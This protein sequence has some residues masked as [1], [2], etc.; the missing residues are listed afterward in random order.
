MFKMSHLMKRKQLNGKFIISF[1][2]DKVEPKHLKTRTPLNFT[3]SEPS[4]N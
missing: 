1:S 3:D 4:L 2:L